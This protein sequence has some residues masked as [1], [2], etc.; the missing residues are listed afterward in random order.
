MYEIVNFE[1]I[2]TS[3]VSTAIFQVFSKGL[4][5]DSEI[6]VLENGKSR[7]SIIPK[8]ENTPKSHCIVFFVGSEGEIISD[9]ITLHFENVLPNYV[10]MLL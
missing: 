7:F 9:S 4:L 10:R 8:F 1:V 2:T 5:I 3:N 6:I